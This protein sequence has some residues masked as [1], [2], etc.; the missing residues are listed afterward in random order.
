MTIGEHLEELRKRLILAIIGFAVA[1]AICLWFG[2][3][4]MRIFCQPLVNVL[5]AHDLPPQ[6]VNK[7]LSSPFVVYINVSLIC[8]LVLA[9][10]WIIWQFWSTLR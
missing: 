8:S 5:R 2:T 10:P 3:D 4:V 6:L 9:A 1:M 7:E